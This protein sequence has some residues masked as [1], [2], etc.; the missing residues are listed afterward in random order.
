VRESPRHRHSSFIL[1]FTALK[2]KRRPA[3]T[4]RRQSDV[5][6]QEEEEEQERDGDAGHDQELSSTKGEERLRVTHWQVNINRYSKV[7]GFYFINKPNRVSLTFDALL[8]DAASAEARS[9]LLCSDVRAVRACVR[10]VPCRACVRAVRA[11]VRACRAC[12]RV[13]VFVFVRVR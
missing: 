11:C 10:A 2:H 1:S 6:T 12:V 9:P 4:R 7:E 5:N 8:A 13:C 3:A